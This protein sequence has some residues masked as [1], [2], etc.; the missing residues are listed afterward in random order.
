M[1][2]VWRAR[3]TRLGREVALKV[4]PQHMADTEDARTRLDREA[5][6]I[7]GLN[8]PHI[9]TLFD[10]GRD[11]GTDYLVMELLEG[12]TLTARIA[13]GALPPD[14][15]LRVAIQ[16]TDALDA[17]HRRGIV[18]R[19]LK[20]GNVMLTHS[21]AKLMD[22]GL[23]RAMPLVGEPSNLNS[24]LTLSRSLTT[25]GTL[26][27]TFVY[28]APEQ[29]EGKEADAR[30]DLWALGCV[31]YEMATG[32]RAFDGKSQASL[33]GTIM[34]ADPLST[35]S[36][37][38]LT[39]LGLDR[40]VKA[41]LAKNPDERIQTAHDVKLQLQWVA[42]GGSQAGLPAPV[43][44]RQRHRAR[45]AWVLAAVVGVLGVWSVAM[46][47][48]RREP[49]PVVTRY[50]LIP[51]SSMRSMTWP[52]LSPDGRLLAFQAA[53]TLGRRMIWVRPLN[54]FAAN[55]L[56]GTEDA[57]RPF[58]SPDSK[59]VAYFIGNQLKKIA[60]AG[61]PPQLICET[62][63]AADGAWGARDVIL[64]DGA[65]GDS[66]RQVS[67]NGGVASEATTFDRKEGETE[68]AWPCFLPD[69]RHFLFLAF[70]SKGV[71]DGVLKLGAL[72]SPEVV[73]LGVVGSRAEFAPPDLLL[74]ALDS[75]LMARRLDMRR[76]RWAGDPFPV[77]EQI[78][79]RGN[80]QANFSVSQTG[81][82][83]TMGGG[84]TDRS[85]LVWVDRSGQ[86]LAREGLPA[87]YR[88]LALS[89]DGGR[90]AYGLVDPKKGTQDLWVR[91]LKRGVA[92]RLT[93]GEGSELWPVWSPDGTSVVYASDAKG[94][95]ALMVKLADGTG[96]EDTLY[97][98][99]Y[100][101]GP[102]DW[103]RDGRRI[104]FAAFPNG[105]ADVWSLSA[106][107]GRDAAQIV[108]TPFSESNGCFSPDGRWLAYV[109]SESGRPEIYVREFPGPGGKWQISAGG[110]TEPQW[111]GNGRELF[112]RGDNGSAIMAAPVAAT[113]AFQVGAVGRLFDATLTRGDVSR[114]RYVAAADGQRFLLNLP[115]ESHAVDVFN[116]VLN[117]TAEI[118]QK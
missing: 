15:L 11:N 99:R 91:D 103:S 27:G 115:T 25:E 4:L 55:A 40:V 95:F 86:R 116:V 88:D 54:A 39:P 49:V 53:D 110:G 109:S 58:W 75:T 74:Y 42:E 3:D 45:W 78:M 87:G 30:S 97:A 98:P 118:A 90:L 73:S 94:P 13:K 108:G 41:C 105:N 31:L 69:G 19:D 81:V 57:G 104:L 20:P 65:A 59:Y 32:Q 43:A 101:T 76:W 17:A 93:F 107:D 66:L 52:R 34:H 50:G 79:V 8:H 71:T 92:S 112:F 37:P 68:H 14:E 24:S 70:G 85:E 84:S 80:G 7:S 5:R 18:H 48:T 23:A 77:A 44:T 82:L 96:V 72:D 46:A 83:A 113:A 62:E 12:E 38:T 51:E 16:I 111:R 9:C 114:N 21:G 28:M 64:F 29:L 26:V 36:A 60:V 61:G 102:S 106:V 56:P 35:A 63:S 6:A 2:V 10:I 47:A 100:H 117:W 22:F 89:P 67:A 33:I 1:G